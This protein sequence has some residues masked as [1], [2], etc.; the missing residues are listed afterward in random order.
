M[1]QLFVISA[2]I[3]FVL[4]VLALPFAAAE[5]DDYFSVKNNTGPYTVLPGDELVVVFTLSNRDLVSPKNVTAVID[6]CPVGWACETDT[7]SFNKTGNHEVNLTVAIPKTALPKKYTMHILLYSYDDVTRGD[8]TFIVTVLSEEQANAISYEEYLARQRADESQED[9]QV[10]AEDVAAWEEPEEELPDEEMAEK[11][12]E[13]EPEPEVLEQDVE[14]GSDGGVLPEE[15]SD[16]I[17][18]IDTSEITSNVERLETSHQFV[19]YAS[20]VLITLLVFIALGMYM[21]FR[22][23]E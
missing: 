19:E 5:L 15:G 4:L 10:S 2:L 17:P 8:D 6:G 14:E 12:V 22:K 18:G 11:V 21:T 23:K 9:V 3:P 1:K 16:M 7:F 20:I 13:P